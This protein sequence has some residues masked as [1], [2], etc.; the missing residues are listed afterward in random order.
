MQRSPLRGESALGAE[1]G[2]RAQQEQVGPAADQLD[3]DQ[4]L[5]ELGMLKIQAQDALPGGLADGHQGRAAHVFAQQLQQGRGRVHPAARFLA[6]QMDARRLLVGRKQQVMALPAGVDLQRQAGRVY[7]HNL[8]HA[9]GHDRATQFVGDGSC[10]PEVV[11]HGGVGSEVSRCGSVRCRVRMCRVRRCQVSGAEVSVRCRV[12]K[13]QV[14]SVGRSVRAEVSRCRVEV[15]GAECRVRKR[16]SAD[17]SG[18]G[19]GSVECGC[20]GCRVQCRVRSIRLR[21]C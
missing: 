17:V 21:P 15:S 8:L 10:G 16:S 12:R 3:D 11:G 6:Q 18:V 19:C 5:A 13:C 2:G 4:R 7:L 1:E 14:R 20:V 9:T